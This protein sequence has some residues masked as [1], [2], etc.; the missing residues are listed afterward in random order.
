MCDIFTKHKHPLG[1]SHPSPTNRGVVI[2]SITHHRR[3]TRAIF[4]VH[5]HAL[6]QMEG[7]FR[8]Q[9]I[10]PFLKKWLGPQ[11]Q[12]TSLLEWRFISHIYFI[13]I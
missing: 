2:T 6:L 9:A 3:V 1:F 10:L 11:K 5:Q 8:H 4:G 7:A 12:P 13:T